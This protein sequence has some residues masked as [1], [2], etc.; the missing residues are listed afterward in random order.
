MSPEY[1]YANTHPNTF[2][3]SS[4]FLLSLVLVLVV[5]NSRLVLRFGLSRRIASKSGL[6][7]LSSRDVAGQR[8]LLKVSRTLTR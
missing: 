7:G 3:E 5:N 6:L 4:S 8:N 1:K 2:S